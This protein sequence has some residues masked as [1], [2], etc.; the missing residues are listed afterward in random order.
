MMH[1]VRHFA[2][3]LHCYDPP[4]VT[5]PHAAGPSGAGDELIA[6]LCQA[7]ALRMLATYL[8]TQRMMSAHTIGFEKKSN[9]L[10]ITTHV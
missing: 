8:A 9:N 1:G 2:K 4:E 6:K 5:L 10:A 3:D 7:L